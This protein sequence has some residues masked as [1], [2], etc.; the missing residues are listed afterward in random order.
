[1][2]AQEL[3]LTPNGED[4]GAIGIKRRDRSA[5]SWGK[6]MQMHVVPMEMFVPCIGPWVN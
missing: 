3:L 5:S 6:A 1:M 4:Q 2:A